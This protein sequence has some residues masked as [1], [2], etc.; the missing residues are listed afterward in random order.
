MKKN[1]IKLTSFI[2]TLLLSLTTA[3]AEIKFDKA[4]D[5]FFRIKSVQA[6]ENSLKGEWDQP[7]NNNNF[8]QGDNLGIWSRETANDQFYRFIPA[9]DGWYNIVS[10]NKGYVDVAGG[11][12]GDGVNVQIWSP[13]GTISQKFRL[14][15]Q[16]DGRWKIY[17]FW[18]R[19]LCTPRSF[20]NGS[21]VHTW[22]DHN[23]SW[24]EWYLISPQN[25]KYLPPAREITG[26]VKGYSIDPATGKR[27][28]QGVNSFSIDVWVFNPKDPKNQYVKAETIK[29][30]GTGK[31][32]L[33]EKYTTES[34]IMLL[35]NNPDRETAMVKL[36][37]S[38]GERTAEIASDFYGAD[39]Y[40]LLDTP[41]RGKKY[42]YEENG[43]F[44]YKNGTVTRRDSFFFPDINQRTPAV[45]SLIK[46][47][48]GNS[49]ITT[50]AEIVSRVSGVWNFLKS[51]AKPSMGTKDPKVTEAM[52]FLFRNSYNNPNQ[53]GGL[54]SVKHWPSITDYADTYAKF[55][56]IPLG[57][58][59]SWS[60]GAATL[61]YAAGVPADKF[62]V[63][64]FNYD[65]S[66][67]V[68]HW[69]IAVN[70]NSRWYSLDPQANSINPGNTLSTFAK[71]AYF[72]NE[73]TPYNFTNPFEAV[74]LPGSAIN[75]VPYCGNP[76][77]IRA[78]VAA[79]NRPEFFIN[80]KTFTY[81]AGGMAYSS[82]GTAVVKKINGNSADVEINS[83]S[84]VEGPKGMEKKSS[85][86]TV[87][88]TVKNGTYSY[89]AGKDYIYTGK[90]DSNGKS[91]SM[92]GEQDGFT[93]T[94]K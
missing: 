2:L 67:I 23:G 47:L 92:S 78:L 14:V 75:K 83:V 73:N 93:L 41:Y 62:F 15:H 24:M 59:T 21:N 80:N 90:I 8:R 16:G 88:F 38:Q 44:Y 34:S 65:M 94:V 87:T 85:K 84:T 30:D 45:N 64:K 26:S 7:G 11:K 22:N 63:S 49:K 9:G 89:A 91:L 46:E 20:E 82:S 81:S 71:H 60:Q 40:I 18:G 53:A 55:G 77:K 12:N 13:N 58:C 37:P 33:S 74:L 3:H 32:T 57:N 10:A 36:S 19:A 1:V 43:Y 25:K 56:F 86:R 79:K 35:A 76:E 29:T 66:W 48:G 27:Q 61:L 39:N 31:F 68:E 5:G 51:K 70:V 6:G 50:D 54:K 42:Y 17:T 72:T 52:E 69:V 4:P 28:L